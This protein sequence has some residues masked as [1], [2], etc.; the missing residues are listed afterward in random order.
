VLKPTLGGAATLGCSIGCESSRLTCH[1]S[2]RPHQDDGPREKPRK[3]RNRVQRDSFLQQMSRP[4]INL[5]TLPVSEFA[6]SV[7]VGNGPTSGSFIA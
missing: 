7:N 3:N 4:R 1:P 5:A 6:T 2:I